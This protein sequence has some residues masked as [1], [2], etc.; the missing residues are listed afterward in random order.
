MLPTAKILLLALVIDA[1]VGD[2]AP[3]YRR[4]PH[5]VALIGRVIAWLDRRLN[6]DDWSDDMRRLAGIFACLLLIVAAAVLGL[7]IERLLARIAF[8]WAIL[9][10]LTSL[11]LAQN[12]LYRHV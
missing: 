11:L 1:A 10:A 9:A 12:S 5:P 4:L 7:G 3:L 6:H 8:G 2:P